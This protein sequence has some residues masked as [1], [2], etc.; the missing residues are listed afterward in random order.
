M[1]VAKKLLNAIE[2]V[3][4]GELFLTITNIFISIVL[5]RLIDPALFGIFSM[6]LIFARLFVDI[7]REG[8]VSS[9]IFKT[10]VK[11]C[12]LSALFWFFNF[13]S[14][15]LLGITL[16][17]APYFVELN[18]RLG[19]HEVILFFVLYS[20]FQTNTVIPHA[21]L[22][23]K[24]A[25]KKI[26]Q[27]EIWATFISG[28]VSIYLAIQGFEIWAILTRV[29]LQ[30]SIKTLLLQMELEWIPTLHFQLSTIIFHLTYSMPL[31]LDHFL[32]FLV[33]N[34][35]DFLIGITMGNR[36]L[37]LYNRSYSLLVF[38]I[39]KIGKITSSVIFPFITNSPVS[40]KEVSKLYLITLKLVTTLSFLVG[41]LIWINSGFI[42]AVLLGEKWTDTKSLIKI[43]AILGA[44]Q[45]VGTFGGTFFKYANKT[46]L[47]L[48]IGL[49][50]KSFLLVMILIGVYIEGSIF[51]VAIYYTIGSIIGLIPELFFLTRILDISFSKVVTIILKKLG[52][53]C[54]T[55]MIIYLLGSNY[56]LQNTFVDFGVK[57]LIYIMVYGTFLWLFEKDSILT[58]WQY[59]NHS[60]K[61][62][63]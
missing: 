20:I 47:L 13:L 40:S 45:S 52:F 34:F 17:I 24:L 59:F 10:D 62:T 18:G 5:I 49:I 53:L 50:I 63:S 2:I 44:F 22:Q 9:I 61:M 11:F 16:L 48:K 23:K 32:N 35:D 6:V 60:I 39:T 41:G 25:F 21:V 4:K 56:P 1:H 26:R 27:V 36:A 37:G 3:A 57:S 51:G 42:S 14:L 54:S 8:F 28:S 33:R 38:P 19:W 58:I 7:P 15:V 29:L 31:M 43:F 46:K 12:E 30:C 55:I